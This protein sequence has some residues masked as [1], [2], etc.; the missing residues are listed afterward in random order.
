MLEVDTGGA[1]V[2]SA[3]GNSPKMMAGAAVQGILYN[4]PP[5]YRL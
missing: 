4:Q 3:G 2:L 5:I 1:L